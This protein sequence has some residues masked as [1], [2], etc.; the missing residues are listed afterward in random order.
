M[1]VPASRRATREWAASAD[2][3]RA[4]CADGAAVEAETQQVPER[5][6]LDVF[7]MCSL[8]AAVQGA[9]DRCG[10]EGMRHH[11]PRDPYRQQHSSR[12]RE[13][14]PSNVAFDT[15]RLASESP[16][17]SIQQ[18]DATTPLRRLKSR[19]SGSR[20]GWKHTVKGLLRCRPLRE[21][22]DG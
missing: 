10:R 3:V 2:R 21:R 5:E 15:R 1:A 19:R 17:A 7:A 6:S 9:T 20:K 8:T 13:R 14:A 18:I 11:D 4:R 22:K 12:T 16:D